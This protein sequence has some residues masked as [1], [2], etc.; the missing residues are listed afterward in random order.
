MSYIIFVAIFA[1]VGLWMAVGYRNFGA[2]EKTRST[3]RAAKR[4]RFSERGRDEAAPTK[5]KKARQFGHP[6]R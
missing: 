5:V 6:K 2:A 1:A 4:A 3:D